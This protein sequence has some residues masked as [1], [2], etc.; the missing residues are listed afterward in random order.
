[1][2]VKNLV[3]G[4]PIRRVE[5]VRLLTGGG[6][7]TS[8]YSPD[9]ELVSFVLRSPYAHANFMIKDLE[10]AKAV[11]GVKLIL[12]ADDV[13]DLGD[14]PCLAP[15]ENDDGSQNHVADIPVLAKGVVKFVGDAIAFVVAETLNAAKEAA[16]A[17]NIEFKALPAVSDIRSAMVKGAP[18]VWPH[19]KD[20]LAY[21]KNL[22]DHKKIDAIFAKAH[23][24]L[25][26]EIENNRLIT[27]YMET[28]GAVGEYDSTTKT[29]KLTV[30]SQAFM[31]CA[32]RLL[33]RS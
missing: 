8:D 5:D 26:I 27:N 19:M 4:Q 16:E 31:A 32:T 17:I 18:I 22:G 6:H 10:A 11:K 21:E 28:R 15:L 29:M 33:K 1:M 30:A 24:V 12:T 20:N 23:R 25:T 2:S 14:V 7:Y 9:K 13:A 3:I